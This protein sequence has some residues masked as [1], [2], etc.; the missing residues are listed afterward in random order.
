MKAREFREM[1]TEELQEELK[2][3]RREL[4]NLRH[5]QTIEQLENPSQFNK[6]KKDVARILTVL[7][8]RQM[9]AETEPAAG[10]E[11]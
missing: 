8:E 3:S 5:Q 4:Y 9:A 6:T 2:N 1:S 10:V 11:K 7:K